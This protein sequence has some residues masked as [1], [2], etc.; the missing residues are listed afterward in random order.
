V[1]ARDL[2]SALVGLAAFALFF[3]LGVAHESYS[4]SFVRNDPILTVV[5]RKAYSVLA[6]AVLGYAFNFAATRSW[7]PLRVLEGALLVSAASALIEIAQDLHGSQEGFAWNA[8]DVLLGAL[9]GALGV[10][11]ARWA[12]RRSGH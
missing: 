3:Y 10:A 7:R 2:V 1:K 8:G 6:F 5:L 11:L 9:G 12:Q 4:A